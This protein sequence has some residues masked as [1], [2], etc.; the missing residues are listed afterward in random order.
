MDDTRAV[1]TYVPILYLFSLIH[2]REDPECQFSPYTGKFFF[3]GC[4]ITLSGL[5][6][7]SYGTCPPTTLPD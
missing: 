1:Y 6:P 7:G 4:L 3:Q 5:L 2:G